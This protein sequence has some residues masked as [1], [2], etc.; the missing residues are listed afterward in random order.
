MWD[1]L[2]NWWKT[3]A[4]LLNPAKTKNVKSLLYFISACAKPVSCAECRQS[5][6]QP[7]EIVKKK[8]SVPVC[9]FWSNV[10]AWDSYKKRLKQFSGSSPCHWIVD[11]L[12]EFL[13]SE[14]HLHLR[15][16]I[17]IFIRTSDPDK[18]STEF[19]TRPYQRTW[20][21]ISIWNMRVVNADGVCTRCE[22]AAEQEDGNVV[23][24]LVTAPN[25]IPIISEAVVC[26]A[27]KKKKD[28]W[29][30]DM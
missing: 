24:V 25:L 2:Y 27:G 3:T 21:R 20:H 15:L 11:I 7:Q 10:W 30:C 1:A 4:H 19:S 5:T 8:R 12:L 16:H 23:D 22:G 29:T 18:K 14:C 6:F 17:T 26:G 9:L 13:H 28:C